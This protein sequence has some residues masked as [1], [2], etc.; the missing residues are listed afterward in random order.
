MSQPYSAAVEQLLRA[1][2][3]TGRYAS[4][5]EVLVEA[6]HSLDE[7]DEELQAIEA[8]LLSI[9]QGDEGVPLNQAFDH[10]R[11]KYQI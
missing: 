5:D 11:T 2:M 4:E 8:R 1:R 3:A 6:L 9:D 10:L 7:S